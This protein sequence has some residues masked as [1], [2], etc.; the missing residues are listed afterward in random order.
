[1]AG[2]G[3]MELEHLRREDAN[4][5]G[6]V[7]E[8]ERKL[9][10][11]MQLRSKAASLV[12]LHKDKKLRKEAQKA[13]NESNQ[14]I[15]R[16]NLDL[17]KASS[18]HRQVSERLHQIE[19]REL[20]TEV[21]NLKGEE[22][23]PLP[24]REPERRMTDFQKNTFELYQPSKRASTMMAR[25]DSGNSFV[26][27][28]HESKFETVA[29]S[30]ASSQPQGHGMHFPPPPVTYGMPCPPSAG[31]YLPP[32]MPQAMAP[33]GMGY[34]PQGAP[35]NGMLPGS[36]LSR[37]S[38][39]TSTTSGVMQYHPM[40][41]SPLQNAPSS[42]HP[43]ASSPREVELAERVRQQ[44]D[45]LRQKDSE[46]V[47]L[48]SLLGEA[49][50]H[51][52]RM[53][54]QQA[55]SPAQAELAGQLINV[56]HQKESLEKQLEDAKR[57]IGDLQKQSKDA[58]P[59]ETKL[60]ALAEEN[61]ATKNKLAAIEAERDQLAAKVSILESN[62]PSHLAHQQELERTA[63]K[64]ERDLVNTEERRELLEQLYNSS[65]RELAQVVQ[66][67]M[68]MENQ[69]RQTGYPDQGLNAMK[70][71][72][73]YKVK[74]DALERELEDLQTKYTELEQRNGGSSRDLSVSDSDTIAALQAKV[75]SVE[76]T[77]IATKES[78]EQKRASL[79]ITLEEVQAQLAAVTSEKMASEA[80]LSQ[81]KPACQSKEEEL[82]ELR[83]RISQEA[84]QRRV[85]ESELSGAR[86]QIESHEAHITWLEGEV[87]MERTKHAESS[88]AFADATM[89]QQMEFESVIA[90]L[91][92][93]VASAKNECEEIKADRIQHVES[94][95]SLADASLKRQ[96][97]HDESIGRLQAEL[98]TARREID[99]LKELLAT[100][101]MSKEQVQKKLDDE[102]TGR[103]EDANGFA[104]R[105]EDIR[106]GLRREMDEIVARHQKQKD[107]LEGELGEVRAHLQEAVSGNG[108]RDT[109]LAA[110]QAELAAVRS[111]GELIRAQ[112]DGERAEAARRVAISEEDR[113]N[114][115]AQL[116]VLQ[117]RNSELEARLTEAL[118]KHDNLR[119]VHA[120]AENIAAAHSEK[121]SALEQQL[122]DARMLVDQ[123]QESRDEVDRKSASV[124]EE[125]A[126]ILQELEAA[127]QSLAVLRGECEELNAT[128][129]QLG[130]VERELMR[131]VN[132]RDDV[133]AKRAELE[134]D[135]A[136]VRAS[137]GD[138]A[139]AAEE[140]HAR[141][142]ESLRQQIEADRQRIRHLEEEGARQAEVVRGLQSGIAAAEEA[143]RRDAERTAQSEDRA[144]AL[145]RDVESLSTELAKLGVHHRTAAESVEQYKEAKGDLERL[146]EETKA[147]YQAALKEV[148]ELTQLVAELRRQQE[149]SQ[150]TISEVNERSSTQTQELQ[151][152]KDDLR[153]QLEAAADSNRVLQNRLRETE[154]LYQ[155]QLATLQSDLDRARAEAGSRMGAEQSKIRALE[156]ELKSA[157]SEVEHV[158]SA[159]KPQT[160]EE[161]LQEVI[162]KNMQLAIELAGKEQEMQELVR[163]AR[164]DGEERAALVQ[165]IEALEAEVSGKGKSWWG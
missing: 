11:E 42:Y 35:Y 23:P 116:D 117:K 1:M 3:T 160:Y 99:E 61:E 91:Q 101:A 67:S 6:R 51:L 79:K 49:E 112:M 37:T 41:P 155:Q 148:E 83:R 64:F 119:T 110:L 13:F 132:E 15:E 73:E 89:K 144:Q 139:Q 28:R 38:S 33:Q 24:D 40:P 54:P 149:T 109:R 26:P 14:A 161:Q 113:S 126:S 162:E 77:L 165:K 131:V 43:A 60:A 122:V 2:T 55:Q 129:T 146:L 20:Q 71:A 135:L 103:R 4:L 157:Q 29:R 133:L 44:T 10:V 62:E 154:E 63:R 30:D 7:K 102:V 22:P 123:L 52:R 69:L 105:M 90:K 121:M 5:A 130:Q 85:I 70:Q 68:L 100:A 86:Q 125:R 111:E 36:S 46:I 141:E 80:S 50:E 164:K 152:A 18:Q 147:A 124:M 143:E 45:L 48:T 19:K 47:N 72:S 27:P 94:S 136:A 39:G 95:Q 137:G 17:M 81:M 115:A 34:R 66:R 58:V 97:E 88:R 151:A 56:T 57:T 138:I 59:F 78:A 53:Q 75:A 150:L 96:A 118:S 128:R 21:A 140:A 156:S 32:H 153:Q 25:T 134:R 8:L 159:E 106:A 142:V 163:R 65:R 114:V 74:A 107:A 158:L 9:G 104:R 16:L 31:P 76:K 93:E 84:N 127:R 92:A 82:E 108:D 145:A 98:A 12:E 120:E 87:Q